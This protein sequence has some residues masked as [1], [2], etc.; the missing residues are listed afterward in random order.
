MS[1][2]GSMVLF[3]KLNTPLSFG[4]SR[5]FFGAVEERCT[6]IKVARLSQ[7][8]RQLRGRSSLSG[9]FRCPTNCEARSGA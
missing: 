1:E 3:G 5:Q 4:D 8:A 7:E 6:C 9:D 2:V